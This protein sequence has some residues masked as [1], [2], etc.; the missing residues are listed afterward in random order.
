[1]LF[2]VSFPDND[3][4]GLS[5]LEFMIDNTLILGVEKDLLIDALG[6]F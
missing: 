3:I 1:M 6:D 2:R 4:Q 5:S